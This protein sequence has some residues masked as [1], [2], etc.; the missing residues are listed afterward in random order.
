MRR[1][2][3]LFQIIQVLRAARGPVT[4]RELADELEVSLRTLYRDMA[5]LIAQRVPITGEAGMGYVLDE[6]YDMPP[7]MLKADELEAAVLGAGLV[8]GQADPTLARAARDLVVKLTEAIPEELRPV[9][10]DASSRAIVAKGPK[11]ERFDGARLRVAIRERFKLRV[12]YRDGGGRE[13]SRVIWPLLIA[14]FVGDRFIV[15]WCETRQD[16]RHFRTDRVAALD[17]LNE[18]YSGRRA[19]L[20]KG[21]EEL[22]A[23]RKGAP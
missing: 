8:A 23:K 17:V 15:A 22:M 16:Y 20:I 14:Y 9:V 2:E 5:E 12:V 11:A 4:G 7:L 19:E 1:T 21:W 13:S 18:V 6:G 3:R 10:L